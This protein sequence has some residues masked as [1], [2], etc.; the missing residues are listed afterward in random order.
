MRLS[1]PMR[2]ANEERIYWVNTLSGQLDTNPSESD[3]KCM[4]DRG[5]IPFVII[6][7]VCITSLGLVPMGA[8]PYT[9]V[10]GPVTALRAQR[11]FLLLSFAVAAVLWLAAAWVFSRFFSV[12]ALGPVAEAGA[13][14]GEFSTVCCGLRC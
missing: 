10:H 9:A 14:A 13:G 12:G 4:R 5:L 11:A 8:G 2:L 3:I 6:A 1:N 7:S